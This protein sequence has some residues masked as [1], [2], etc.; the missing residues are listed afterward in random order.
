MSAEID[1]GI[2]PQSPFLPR[3]RPNNPTTAA[4]MP[5]PKSQIAL[6][7]GAPVKN[8]DISEPKESEALN[9]Q[10]TKTI[11]TINSAI[12]IPLFIENLLIS[13]V[14]VTYD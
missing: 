2:D 11:P 8:R 14:K 4:I 12:D 10:I 9:P 7:V 5:P 6:L 13:W 3:K 1:H